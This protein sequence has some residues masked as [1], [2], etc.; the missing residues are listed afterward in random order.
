MLEKIEFLSVADIP[1]LILSSAYWDGALKK[2]YLKGGEEKKIRED[3]EFVYYEVKKRKDTRGD[4]L[5]KETWSSKEELVNESLNAIFLTINKGSLR[6]ILEK[7]TKRKV[8]QDY[9]LSTIHWQKDIRPLVGNPDMVFSSKDKKNIILIEFKISA[10]A[11]NHKFSVQQ[12][13]KYE[14]LR[15]I[16]ESKGINVEF[17]TLSPEVNFLDSVEKS[18]RTL[19]VKEGSSWC[20][21]ETLI[22]SS[23]IFKAGA[24][25]YSNFSEYKEYVKGLT[26]KYDL[27]IDPFNLK[28]FEHITLSSLKNYISEEI[29]HLEYPMSQL[30]EYTSR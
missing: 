17:F 12:Q 18:E 7:V 8:E 5:M 16:L 24:K 9:F 19:F 21:D 20:F 10:K 11:G 26:T 1:L 29:P 27:Q 25:K 14:A 13:I 22:D 3:G 28:S 4:K 2:M 30:I 15:K 23:T 6:K